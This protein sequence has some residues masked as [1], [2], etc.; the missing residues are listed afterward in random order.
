MTLRWNAPATGGAVSSYVLEIGSS[1]G[2]SNLLSVN[3]GSSTTVFVITGVGLGTHYVRVKAVTAA[4]NSA[5]SNE[6]TFDR[7]GGGGG[8]GGGGNAAPSNLSV[9]LAGTSATLTWTAPT[10]GG[11]VTGYIVEVGS[12]SGASDLLTVTTGPSTTLTLT[13]IGFGTHY[14]RVRAVTASGTSTPSNEAQF[15]R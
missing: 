8:G 4:G 7:S 10:A 13:G 12:S 2:A 11:V 5:A 9:S 14:V 3:T 15:S 6:A 1:S